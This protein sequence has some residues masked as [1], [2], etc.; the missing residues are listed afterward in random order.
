MQSS[1][2]KS[3]FESSLAH[4]FVSFC[5]SLSLGWAPQK[6]QTLNVQAWKE[7]SICANNKTKK[8]KIT[9]CIN[10]KEADSYPPSIFS[11]LFRSIYGVLCVY[12][13][14]I[15]ARSSMRYGNMNL[16]IRNCPAAT[17][18][19]T[20]NSWRGK[21]YVCQLLICFFM[22]YPYNF[23]FHIARLPMDVVYVALWM[24]MRW[25][26]SIFRCFITNLWPCLMIIVLLFSVF[27]LLPLFSPLHSK[28]TKSIRF[29]SYFRLRTSFFF[30]RFTLFDGLL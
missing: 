21:G 9:S 3:P 20:L 15:L 16:R 10:F 1:K 2:S 24:Q 14:F 18:R 26:L 25:L 7:K 13:F 11:Q 6:Y 17:R 27:F 30:S 28:R 19:L 5:L 4:S 29:S 23:S 12:V 22:F 8:R